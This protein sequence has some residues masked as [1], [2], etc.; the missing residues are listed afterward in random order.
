MRTAA[1]IAILSAAPVA[2][3]PGYFAWGQRLHAPRDVN[4]TDSGHQYQVGSVSIPMPSR[5][6]SGVYLQ[7][8]N[9]WLDTTTETDGGAIT[10]QAATVTLNGVQTNVTFSAATS[11]AFTAGQTFVSDLLALSGTG[12]ET[13]TIKFAAQSAISANRVSDGELPFTAIGE[14][15]QYASTDLSAKVTDGTAILT[16]AN[17]SL[18]APCAI[19]VGGR[20][21]NEPAILAVGDSLMEG[22]VESVSSVKTTD[23]SGAQGLYMRYFALEHI[24]VLNVSKFGQ[25]AQDIAANFTKRALIISTA[26]AAIGNLP[27]SVVVNELCTNDATSSAATWESRLTGC[28]G[29]LAVYSRPILQFAALTR[30]TSNAAGSWYTTL[31]GQTINTNYDP[32]IAPLSTLLAWFGSGA[33]GALSAFYNVSQFLDPA[34]V[35]KYDPTLVTRTGTLVGAVS[36]GTTAVVTGF[37][38]EKGMGL[39]FLGGTGEG[40]L[41]T[42]VTGPSGG[43]YTVTVS[44]AFAQTHAD[45]STVT[46]TPCSP[47]DGLHF[48]TPVHARL[49]ASLH[50]DAALRTTLNTLSIWAGGAA[51]GPATPRIQED[52]TARVLEDGTARTQES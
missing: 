36:S 25:R 6:W 32:S 45:G 46:E 31:A 50:A 37:V 34:G 38:P 4:V 22:N 9:S 30:T 26:Q 14:T 18:F 43:N 16:T 48:P 49:A 8:I 33:S 35:G 3:A 12:G 41:I 27:F 1:R 52:S 17:Q 39:A 21:V 5:A 40:K 51:A 42:A 44:V 19:Y 11:K 23:A 2:I 29:K 7:W 10:L 47:I 13:L 20:P 28:Y 15:G 24:G